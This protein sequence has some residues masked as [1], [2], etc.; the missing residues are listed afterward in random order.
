MVILPEIIG[1]LPSK[2]TSRSQ[3]ILSNTLLTTI[4]FIKDRA[5]LSTFKFFIFEKFSCFVVLVVFLVIVQSPE[6]L[7]VWFCEK[8]TFFLNFVSY[9]IFAIYVGGAS[10]GLPTACRL[11]AVSGARL[12]SAD[13][14]VVR[15]IKM[16]NHVKSAI[17]ICLQ[18][19][20]NMFSIYKC[21][22][23]HRGSAPVFMPTKSSVIK[24]LCKLD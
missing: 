13:G 15:C 4:S 19:I 10:L 21:I 5:H 8:I 3:C 7:S 23:T 17:T 18:F 2:N 22:P 20:S 16:H 14:L 1:V 6:L 12:S 24:D 11:I 9:H